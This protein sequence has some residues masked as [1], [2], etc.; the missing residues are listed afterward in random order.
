[1]G[2]N[3]MGLFWCDRT[4]M[5]PGAVARQTQPRLLASATSSNAFFVSNDSD[6]HHSGRDELRQLSGSGTLRVQV[7]RSRIKQRREVMEFKNR[8]ISATRVTQCLIIT[9]AA[10]TGCCKPPPPC[11]VAS[12]VMIAEAV[13]RADRSCLPVVFQRVSAHHLALEHGTFGGCRS[14][15]P[16][17]HLADPQPAVSEIERV[18]RSGGRVVARA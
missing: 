1:M 18:T 6:L 13:K 11:L 3:R 16:L 17:M 12:E 10:R 2:W 4:G 15:R 7:T 8:C 5:L 14:Q 9:S